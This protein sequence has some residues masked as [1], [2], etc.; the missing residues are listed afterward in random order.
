MKVKDCRPVDE[1]IW[2]DCDRLGH[3][4]GCFVMICL[5][6]NERFYDCEEINA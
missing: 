2:E 5:D 4:S 6:C 3:E 1:M